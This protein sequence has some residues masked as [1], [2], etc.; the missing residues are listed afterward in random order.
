MSIKVK[1]K[2]FVEFIGREEIAKKIKELGKAISEDY[3]ETKPLF[4][5]VLN[6]SFIFAA[7]LVREIDCPSET[8]FI[9]LDSYEQL[10]ST[11]NV[12]EIIGLN[13][14][15]FNRKL[16]IIEDIVDTGNTIEYLYKML[17]ELGPASI[18]IVTLL[19]KPRAYKKD[20]YIKYRGF[21]IENKFVLGYGLDYDGEGRNYKDIFKLKDNS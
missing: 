20:L 9:K 8:S 4:I 19:F 13:E 18:E 15:V 21:E 17:Q 14:N 6:G 1:D 2:E 5:A 3:K 10:S 12:K 11:G 16:V 7:D